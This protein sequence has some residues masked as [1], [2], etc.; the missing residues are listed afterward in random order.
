MNPVW[1]TTHTVSDDGLVTP[2]P[3]EKTLSADHTHH[4]ISAGGIQVQLEQDMYES[5]LEGSGE[6]NGDQNGVDLFIVIVIGALLGVT[7]ITTV[8]AIIAFSVVVALTR[9][10]SSNQVIQGRGRHCMSD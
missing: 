1:Y 10:R 2:G 9:K 7:S 3:V 6:Q 4:S 8:V 5:Q